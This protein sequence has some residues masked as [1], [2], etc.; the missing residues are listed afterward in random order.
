MPSV[1]VRVAEVIRETA[2]AV[3]LVL[4]AQLP[5]RPGQF[6]TVRLPGGGARCYSLASSPHTG[7][8]MKV[9][10]KRVA[11][12]VGSGWI[13]DSVAPGDELEVLPPAGTFTPPGLD[14]DVLLVAGGSGITPVV[15]IA[16]SALAAG[17]GR[18]ALLYANRDEESV[19][20]REELRLLGVEFAGRLTVV[21]WLET[22]Q[23]LPTAAAPPICAGPRP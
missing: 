10:V 17:R 7:E 6:M 4:D 13:C 23:G 15:S 1:K 22:L 9:T 16:K 11:G 12:G 20:F 3:S 18:V 14:G 2:D 21:H 8:P 5:Y 19:I